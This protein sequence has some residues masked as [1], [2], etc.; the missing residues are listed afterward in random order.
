M[1]NLMLNVNFRQEA[2]LPELEIG[3]SFKWPDQG[4]Q[5]I[6]GIRLSRLA[7]SF[8]Q[9]HQLTLYN[10][11]GPRQRTTCC[12]AMP[13]LHPH[14]SLAAWWC[15]PAPAAER[16]AELSASTA[17]ATPS[18]PEP[19]PG[20]CH[21]CSLGYT[22]GVARCSGIYQRRLFVTLCRTSKSNVLA[23][24][25]AWF[26]LKWHRSR[27]S[28]RPPSRPFPHKSPVIVT[29]CR[30]VSVQWAADT[31]DLAPAS[32]P[33]CRLHPDPDGQNTAHQEYNCPLLY[34]R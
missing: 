21:N 32:T 34:P 5:R 23:L 18:L 8:V 16:G 20:W 19:G 31:W 9:W 29:K 26:R 4:V 2:L 17:A 11:Y 27:I 3:I 28:R 12:P 33:L 30:R 22:R 1:H 10:K 6:Y 13:G 7:K 25:C 15:A 24:F 14:P